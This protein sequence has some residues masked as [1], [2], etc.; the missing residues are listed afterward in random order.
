MK[1]PHA[2]VLLGS[3]ALMLTACSPSAAPAPADPGAGAPA[4]E[5]DFYTIDG[6]GYRTE[7]GCELRADGA[8]VA[9]FEAFGIDQEGLYAGLAFTGEKGEPP[10]DRAEFH[11]RLG[12]QALIADSWDGTTAQFRENFT[13]VVG[14]GVLSGSGR[15]LNPSSGEVQQVEFRIACEGAGAEIDGPS[16]APFDMCAALAGITLPETPALYEQ[17]WDEG[18]DAG[19]VESAT[20]ETIA[21]CSWHAEGVNGVLDV[22]QVTFLPEGHEWASPAYYENPSNPALGVTA[23]TVDDA[24]VWLFGGGTVNNVFF[25]VEGGVISVASTYMTFEQEPFLAFATAAHDLV[26]RAR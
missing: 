23:T 4:P 22:V 17:E 25:P 19:W 16:A 5:A 15:F 21:S 1:A 11:T 8:L 14:D 20:G 26:E 18:R 24:V 13:V 12:T 3:L 2:L 10:F 6:Q 7:G 9:S